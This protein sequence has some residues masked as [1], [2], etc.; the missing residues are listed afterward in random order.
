MPTHMSPHVL[1]AVV[2]RQLIMRPWEGRASYFSKLRPIAN[3]SFLGC[4]T[5]LKGISPNL[6]TPPNPGLLMAILI[7]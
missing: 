4:Q 2:V 5:W 3:R 1:D 7:S 6:Y